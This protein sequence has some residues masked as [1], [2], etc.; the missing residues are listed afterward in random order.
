MKVRQQLNPLRIGKGLLCLLA[1]FVMLL[2]P[3]GAW[4]QTDYGLTVAGVSVTS[5]N[6]SA[7]TG[8][9]ITSSA[10]SV[11]YNN[12]TQTL[13]LNN[14]RFEGTVNWTNSSNLTIE[15]LG[16]DN[17][18]DAKHQPTFV[19]NNSNAELTL[20]TGTTA[21]SLLITSIYTSEILSGW[22]NNSSIIYYD[23][24]T[25]SGDASN[26]S[27]WADGYSEQWRLRV[28]KKYDLWVD[29]VRLCSAQKEVKF[30]QYDY[31]EVIS[32]DGDHTLT[33]NNV[34]IT[35]ES[36]NPFIKNGLAEL[37]IY[38]KGNN[39]ITASSLFL[40]KY[41]N[42]ETPNV[43]TFKTELGSDVGSLTF[44]SSGI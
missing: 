5:E 30:G 10:G 16:D 27:W 39:T 38:L 41:G 36:E 7:I 12:S 3:Q 18:I 20:T 22:K 25:S 19:G 28:N 17:E 24:T 32:F 31:T 42:G 9:N 21:G 15:I 26:Y 23:E 34:G 1:L 43:V 8:E 4:A 29:N 35:R 44:T 13:T 40:D 6:A 33:I 37:D 2:A 11:S 14:A